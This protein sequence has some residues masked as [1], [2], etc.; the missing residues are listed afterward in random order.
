MQPTALS[1]AGVEKLRQLR[2]IAKTGEWRISIRRDPWKRAFDL[3]FSLVFLLA[4]SPLLLILSFL[5]FTTS[6]GPIFYKSRRLGRGGKVIECWKFR[7]MYKDAE[8]RLHQLLDSDEKFRAEWEAFQKVKH[9]PRITSIGRFLRKTSMDELPQFW[10]VLKGDL[11][12]VGPRPPTLIGPPE[13]FIQEI[14]LLYGDRAAKILS[15]RPG[16]TGVWQI[17]GRS[18]IPFE[19]RCRLEEQYAMNRTFWKDLMVI[20]KTSPAVVLSRGAF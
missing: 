2:T 1:S 18:Q 8:E 3:L 15:V 4:A 6:P 16:I 9:D 13:Q 12:V 5:V 7:S 20:A 19:E 11:S 10:N 14:L 17:S